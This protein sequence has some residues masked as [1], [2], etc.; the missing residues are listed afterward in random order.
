MWCNTTNSSEVNWTRTTTDD[1][2]MDVYINGQFV[3]NPYNRYSIVED[4]LSIYNAQIR[5]SGLWDCHDG[6]VRRS[7]YKLD[8]TGKTSSKQDNIQE[9][10]ESVQCHVFQ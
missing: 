2:F 4:G 6:D 9:N 3:Y 1:V 7:G 10:S 8:I 5:D